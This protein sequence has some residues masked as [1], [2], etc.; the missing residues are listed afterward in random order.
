MRKKIITTLTIA[1]LALPVAAAAQTQISAEVQSLISQINA[2]QLQLK[3]LLAS[4]ASSSTMPIKIKAQ[5]QLQGQVHGQAMPFGQIGKALCIKLTRDLRVGSQG[6][7]VKKLQEMLAQN[8]ETGFMGKATGFFGPLT[9]TAMAKYQMRNG[10]TSSGEGAV[11][12]MTRGF[13]ERACGEGL[14]QGMPQKAAAVGGEITASTASSITV[15]IKDNTSRIVNVT[16]STTIQVFA[17][18]TSTPTAGSMTDLTVG[19]MVRAEGAPQ[20]DGSLR[21]KHIKV[22][23]Q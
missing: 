13:L 6:E 19:K 5:G 16:A 9:A 3:T 23:S 14:G 2:L 8:P 20:A 18:A 7:D 21:A 22:G 4:S 10:I 17:N 11:G 15:K 12:P 1:M